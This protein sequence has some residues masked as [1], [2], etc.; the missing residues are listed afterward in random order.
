M[1]ALDRL[2]IRTIHVYVDR[3]DKPAWTAQIGWL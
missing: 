2:G 3:R 1:A